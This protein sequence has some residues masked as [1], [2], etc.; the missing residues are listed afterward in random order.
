MNKHPLRKYLDERNWSVAEFIERKKLNLSQP[1]VQNLIE[2][3]CNPSKA[4]AE[5]LSEATG[6]PKEVIM[7]PESHSNFIPKSKKRQQKS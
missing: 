3:I 5:K 7:F 4:S 6:I 1:F 2:G